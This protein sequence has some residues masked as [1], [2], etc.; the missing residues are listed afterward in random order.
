MAEITIKVLDKDGLT[1][2]VERGADEVALV[3]TREY[4]EGDEIVVELSAANRFYWVMLD[5]ALQ[6]SLVYLTKDLHYPIPFGERRICMSRKVFAGERHLITVRAARDYE[7]EGR[8]NLALNT[9]DRHGDT[10]C[11]PHASANVETRGESVFAAY[12]AIDGV[13]ANRSHGEWPYQSWGINRR[14]DAE[15][16][17]EFGREVVVDTLRLYTRADFPHDSWWREVKVTFS[18]GSSIIWKLTKSAAAQ[19]VSFEPKRMTS[20]ALSDLIKA[21]DPSPFPALTQLEVIGTEG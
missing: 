15:L 2:F 21:D 6:A 10:G 11:Y 8:R 20:L 16:L 4:N 7:L 17:L 13:K 14:A 3:C 9:C 12:N 5:D 1:L 18:D 19:T